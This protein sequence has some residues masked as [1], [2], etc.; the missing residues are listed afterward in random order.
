MNIKQKLLKAVGDVNIEEIGESALVDILIA[1]IKSL[2]F[3]ITQE[4]A[5]TSHKWLE[6]EH[7]QNKL[8]NEL[9]QL[10]SDPFY[11]SYGEIKFIGR[12]KNVEIIIGFQ[13]GKLIERV[14]ILDVPKTSDSVGF[15][16]TNK[17]MS[18]WDMLRVYADKYIEMG[19]QISVFETVFFLA[20]ANGDKSL[21]PEEKEDLKEKLN[22]FLILCNELDLPT[23][24]ALIKSKLDDLPENARE[25]SML[26]LAAK[27]ELANQLFLFIPPHRAKFYENNTIVSEEVKI[28][29]P[30]ASDEI[31]VAG[32]CF[33][34]GLNTACVFHCMRAVEHGLRALAGELGIVVD[35]QQWHTLIEQIEKE[36]RN[37]SSTLLKGSAKTETMQFYSEAAKEFMYFKDGWRN[38]VSHTRSNYNENQALTT[39]EH[40]RNFISSLSAKL[41]ENP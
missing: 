30:L 14:I 32:N 36:I 25:L 37:Q 38:H 16:Q 34:S 28:A 41:K 10:R 21:H 26:L 7:L 13:G 5:T 27:T 1:R 6:I 8:K 11:G 23:S 31:R 24:S 12:N 17:L 2:E 18:L 40:V 33:A 4:Q 22:V 19:Y 39:L 15:L 35:V 20:D 3:Q 29:F 9:C